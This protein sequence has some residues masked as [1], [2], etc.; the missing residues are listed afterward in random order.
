VNIRPEQR[1]FDLVVVGA[2]PAGLAAAV[3][4]ASEGLSTL[5]LEKYTFGGQAGTS[6]MIRNYLG[7]SRGISGQELATQACLF[8]ASFNLA[9]H[10]TGL[11]RGEDGVVVSLPDGTE[12][13]GKAVIVSP[14]T[15]PIGAW[16]S[17]SSRL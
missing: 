4:G 12:V 9:R 11:R 8:G 10:A 2:G 15:P 17:R 1:T 13:V 16:A 7:C 3:Y 6:S 14:R 5:V